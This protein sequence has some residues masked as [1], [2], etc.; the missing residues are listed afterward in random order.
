MVLGQLTGSSH[1]IETRRIEIYGVDT[2][3]ANKKP[4]YFAQG[5]ATHNMGRKK[6][7]KK[8]TK[9]RKEKEKKNPALSTSS[10]YQPSGEKKL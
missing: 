3:I 2:M 1:G 6:E 8:I 9:K 5:F 7:R 10:E 4:M